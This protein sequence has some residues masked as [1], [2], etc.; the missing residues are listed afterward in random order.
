MATSRLHKAALAY[1]RM[2]WPVFPIVPREK[3]PLTTHGVKDAS[4]DFA[5]IDAWWAGHPDANIGLAC[6]DLVAVDLDLKPEHDGRESWAEL[7]IDDG[8]ALVN[9]TPTGGRHLLFANPNGAPIGNSVCTLGPGIDVRAAGGYIILPPSV[10]P[11]GREYTWEISAHPLDREPGPLPDKL[12]QLLKANGAPKPAPAVEPKIAA[13][14]RNAMLASIAGT[15]RR[16]GLSAAEMFPSLWEVN[17]RR[18]APPLS[19]REVGQIAQSMS[20]YEPK[21]PLV[22]QSEP[23]P[24]PTNGKSGDRSYWTRKYKERWGELR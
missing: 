6:G 2:G 7:D 10:H 8:G 15:M 22:S 17:R 1:A 4:T 16:R 20:R 14:Q 13:G 24:Q 3:R 19:R 9:L 23:P 12:A 21:R 18:C 11:N 5:A